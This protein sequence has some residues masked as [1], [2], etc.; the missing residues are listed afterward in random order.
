MF[1]AANSLCSSTDPDFWRSSA[2]KVTAVLRSDLDAMR[3]YLDVIRD[4]SAPSFGRKRL[5]STALDV[6]GSSVPFKAPYRP[7]DA[8]SSRFSREF[9]TTLTDMDDVMQELN[10]LQMIMTRVEEGVDRLDRKMDQHSVHSPSIARHPR[11]RSKVLATAVSKVLRCSICH[12]ITRPPVTV[13]T[14][15]R[16]W[17]G[18]QRCATKCSSRRCPLCNRAWGENC[19]PLSLRG[20]GELTRVAKELGN[21]LGRQHFHSSPGNTSSSEDLPTLATV[22]QRHTSSTTGA[23]TLL[24]DSEAGPSSPRDPQPGSEIVD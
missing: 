4:T 15:C 11:L 13:T 22:G 9:E 18:C 16:Q 7:S 14:C 17:L 24:H 20:L 8:G 23:D 6:S 12:L 19:Q 3:E 21:I 2:R 1:C 10:G 5:A